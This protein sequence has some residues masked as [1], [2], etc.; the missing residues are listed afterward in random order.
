MGRPPRE[1]EMTRRTFLK[2]T[3]AVG[4]GGAL[5]RWL[6]A[7]A[8]PKSV[9][10]YVG[11]YSDH[12]EGIYLFQVD[13]SSG[14]LTR[15]RVFPS[16]VSP[17][18][19]A[20]GP[21]NRFLYSANEI[22]TFGG[23]PTGSVTAYAVGTNGDLGALNTVS[24]GGTG[25][26][27]LSVDPQGK[28]VFVANYG[29]GTVA[30]VPVRADGSIG[31][32]TQTINDVDAC[33]P[34]CK[35]GP[36]R[37]AKAPEGNFAISGH[38]AAHAH[39]ILTDP[40]GEFVIANDLG[41]DRTIVWKLDRA[42]SRLLNPQPVESSAGA[43]PRHFVFHP[44]GRW[45][46]SLNEQASTVAFMTYENGRLKPMSEVSTLPPG[47]RGTNFSSELLISPSGN[48]LYA[49]NR[50]HNTIAILR[51]GSDGEPTYVGEEWTRGDYPRSFNL[52]PSGRFLYCCNH[53]GDS[54]TVF[55]VR[56]DGLE[57]AFT[58]EYVGVGSPAC[59]IFRTQP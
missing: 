48:V 50:L 15:L 56:R 35:V 16:K 49:G 28:Y 41:L 57:L 39:M 37:A 58:G 27:H 12:G 20:F 17:S 53:R 18:W 38:D 32:P 31:E 19:I 42:S 44:N 3:V 55:A 2:R 54:I 24:S 33:S 30:V 46:Y 7:R 51:V 14:R 8:Q 13:S 23:R 29:G 59:I 5:M 40:K 22:S 26:A 11:T 45:F 6:P 36:G 52:D 9:L 10:A 34:P 21:G 4:A 43:G 25:P 1:Y 47:F